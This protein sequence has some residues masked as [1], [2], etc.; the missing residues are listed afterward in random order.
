MRKFPCCQKPITTIAE[1][2]K[3]LQEQQQLI[4]LN[5]QLAS[6]THSNQYNDALHLFNKIRLLLHHLKPDHYTLSTTLTA[7]A[8]LCNTTF[9]SKLHAHAI[10]SSLKS[11]THVSN[12][13]LLLYANVQDIASVKWVFGEIEDPDVFSYTTLLSACTKMGHVAYAFEIFVEMP[14][15]DVAVWNAMITG[16]VES[17]NKEI[18]F[19]LFRDMCRLGVRHDNYSFASV[20]SGCNLVTVDF[21]LQVHSLA[22]KTGSL[23]RISVVN[24]LV[25]MYFNCENVEDAYLVF[26]EVEDS[27]HDQITYNVMINGLVSVGRVEEALIMFRKMLGNGLRPTEFTFV[28]LMSSCLYAGVGYQFHAQAI[29]FGFEAHTSLSNATINMY[30]SCG[31]LSSACMVFQRLEGKD[32]VSWNTMISSY[33][34]ENFGT[35][36]ILTYLEMQRT[37]IR[38]DEFTFGSLLAGSELVETVEMIHSLLFRNSLIS[39]IQVSN[40]LISAYSKL[41]NMK[42][43]YQIFCDQFY[44]NLISWNTI[45]SGF[46][47]NGL[48]MQGLEQF[49]ELLMSEFRPNE[50]TLSIILSICA[51]ILALRQGKQVHGYIMRLGFS[52]KSSLGNA[53]ITMYAKCGLMHWSLRVFNAMTKRDLVSW[54]ALISA[55]AQHGK[56]NEAVHWFEAMQDSCGVQPD[57]ATFTIILS[58][59][60]HAGLVDDGIRIFNSM[61]CNCGVVP[62]VGHFSCIVDLLG[63]AGHFDEVEMIMNNEHFEPHPNIWWTLLSACAAH[64]NLKLGRLVAGFLLETE[65]DNPSVYV[66]LSNMYAAAGQWEE[67]ANVRYLMNNTRAMKQTGYSWI[68]S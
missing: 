49:S 67:A 29:K 47:L 64:G 28:S 21:G 48:P 20:L 36:A 45:I 41:G 34:Q 51:S 61:V 7:C 37:G 44:R 4:K 53:L 50:Y 55:Y 23:V 17:G 35:S 39:N 22:I 32:I 59:C 56:G 15:K 58:A 54:N 43:A 10:K 18:G 14:Q 24:A 57:E 27:I 25:T 30:S 42:Q 26:D 8:N 19:G 1:T 68:S 46:L 11:Y 6:L 40:A 63:R 60:S 31:D 66:L 5:C 3:I 9:G 2:A 62:G 38:P 12:T 65:Q 16:C 33:A 52:S 13:L